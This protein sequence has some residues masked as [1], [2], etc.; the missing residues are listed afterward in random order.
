[1]V[2]KEGVSCFRG[3]SRC[4]G[5]SKRTAPTRRASG[6]TRPESYFVSGLEFCGPV[7]KSFRWQELVSPRHCG[8][9]KIFPAGRPL[10]V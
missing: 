4:I 8:E 1:V 5:N 3:I 6:E 9:A 7:I 2:A 10:T